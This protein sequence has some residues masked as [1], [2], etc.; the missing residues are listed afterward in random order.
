MTQSHLFNQLAE[1]IGGWQGLDLDGA[2]AETM[3]EEQQQQQ[4]DHATMFRQCFAANAGQYVLEALVLKYL[5]T[6]IV[7]PHDTQFAAG[8]RQGHADVVRDILFLIEL[9]N[10]GGGIP[11]GPGAESE[12]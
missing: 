4:L 12:E 7:E 11:T 9:A 6:R 8:I 2:A 10:T 1:K 5:R 3:S